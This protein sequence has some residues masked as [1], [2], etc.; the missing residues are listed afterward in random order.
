MEVS[1]NHSCDSE[2]ARKRALGQQHQDGQ[3]G[4]VLASVRVSDSRSGNRTVRVFKL[5]VA[6]F[7][8]SNSVK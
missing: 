5:L 2:D 4:A 6:L 8:K 3:H 1:R 7:A